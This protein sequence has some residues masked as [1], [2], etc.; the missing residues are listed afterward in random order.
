[1][2][3]SISPSR[4][5]HSKRVYVCVKSQG[6]ICCYGDIW[7]WLRSHALLCPAAGRITPLYDKCVNVSEVI[8]LFL[9]PAFQFSIRIKIELFY[10]RYKQILSATQGCYKITQDCRISMNP[11]T[12]TLKT[13]YLLLF[14]YAVSL[15]MGERQSNE[16]RKHLTW[17]EIERTQK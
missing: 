2:L 17:L 7:K 11:F 15:W 3:R 8:Y 12:L 1:M 5:E 13:I 4:R 16:P 10:N 14:C 6:C 9:Q